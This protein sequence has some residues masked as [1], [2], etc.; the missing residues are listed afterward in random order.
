MSIKN[1]LNQISLPHRTFNLR[2]PLTGSVD[3]IQ[4]DSGSDRL[5]SQGV[6]QVE[7]GRG[8]SGSPIPESSQITPVKG[9]E[10]KQN[11]KK[12]LIKAAGVPLG[13]IQDLT[14]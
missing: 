5:S 9:Q 2:D 7:T 10:T 11:P 13:L 14:H 8:G 12:S 1:T 4:D 3:R 6:V